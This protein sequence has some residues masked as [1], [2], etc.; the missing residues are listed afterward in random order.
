MYHCSI[1]YIYIYYIYI[2]I[3]IYKY[4]FSFYNIQLVFGIE[5]C[6]CTVWG[7][8]SDAVAVSS[9]RRVGRDHAVVN[10]VVWLVY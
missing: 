5:R 2:C 4:K 1:V 6:S 10:A 8:Q 9:Q 3:Y 7:F